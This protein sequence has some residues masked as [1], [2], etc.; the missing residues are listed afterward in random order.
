[1]KKILV[2]NRGEIA[3]RIMRS[4]KEMGL[5]TVAV[6]STADRKMPFVR[7]ADESVCIGA[8]S[9]TDSYLN[10]NKII[11]VCKDLNVDA[12]HPGY[13]FLSENSSFAKALEEAGVVL[14]GPSANSI[15]MMG[16]KLKAKSAVS[17]YNIPLVPGSAGEIEELNEAIK[18]AGQIGYPVMIKAAAGGGGKGMRI[19]RNELDLKE[20][21]FLAI[22]EATSS[23]GNG[24]VFIEKFIA[25]PRHI[26]FQILADTKGNIVHLNER[27]C[28]IQRRHQKVIEEA[29]SVLLTDMLR[30]EMGRC[31]INVAKSCGYVGA[32]TVEFIVDQDCS[33]YFLEMNTRLQVEHPVTE[34]ITGIDLVKEQIKI[35]RGE[36]LGFE[37]DDI[38]IQGHSIE[39]RV[40][41]EDPSNNFLPDVGALKFYKLPSGRGVRVDDGYEE[42]GEI[43]VHYDPMISKLIVHGSNRSEAIIKMKRAIGDYRIVGVETTLSFCDFVL[44]HDDFITGDF[45]T[46]FVSKHFNK[47]SLNKS[48]KEEAE[49][50]SLIGS[51]VFSG[52]VTGVKSVVNSKE[53]EQES[54]W[55]R[56]RR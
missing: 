39:V 17:Q 50:A 19:A 36:C 29:P 31:A 11:Q 16:D 46:N 38:Q 28:S 5:D 33:Y 21:F 9:A 30:N 4:V 20:N 55:Y 40:Y 15:E 32:G 34:M 24:A 35:A 3:L 23:F 12:V 49:I 45:D 10:I 1:M 44:S 6:F 26:E 52:N 42:N 25:N 14:I 27:E 18:I 51:I 41:A 47:N 48:V 2:A 54:N 56:N 7:Y 43:T 22:S 53:T 37:Q 13:G 8:P